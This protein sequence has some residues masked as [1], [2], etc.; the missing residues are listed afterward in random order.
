MA[1]VLS[2]RP[3]SPFKRSFSDSPHLRSCSPFRDRPLGALRDVASRN[4]SAGSLYT[5]GAI[6]PEY[7][8]RGGENTPPP[9]ASQSLLDLSHNGRHI[10]YADDAPRKRSCGINRPPPSFTRVE[11]PSEPYLKKRKEARQTAKPYFNRETLQDE[12]NIDSGD[13][14]DA[15]L[16]DLY[17]AT[18]IPLP[19]GH[20]S[21]NT[22]NEAYVEAG[23]PP[24]II[25]VTPPPFRRWMSTLR[26][27]HMHR[28]KEA[29]FTLPILSIDDMDAD[30][31]MLSPLASV[32]ESTS[33]R[34]ESMSSSMGCV[35]AMKSASMTLASAS[36]APRSD[37]GTSSQ[38][39][40]RLGKRSSNISE[41]RKSTDSNAAALGPVMDEGAWMRSVQRRK[42]IEEII[43]SEESYIGDLKVLINVSLPWTYIWELS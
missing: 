19:E 16:F 9:L 25:N 18:H 39:R 17:D 30:A 12:V 8:L 1:S 29:V 15:E 5:L 32:P 27:R 36:I 38:T 6:K 24:V 4:I 21:D 2:L 23:Q 40:P 20:F 31:A 10:V 13:H 37:K 33:R 3:Q 42:I 34:S 14:E 43:S 28:R 41:V 7:W 11:V 35:T 22:V 26:R